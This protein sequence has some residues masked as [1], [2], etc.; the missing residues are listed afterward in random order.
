MLATQK[1]EQRAQKAITDGYTHLRT[2][3]SNHMATVYYRFFPLSD[4]KKGVNT[5]ISGRY[6][7]ET[8]TSFAKSN[9][10][11]IDI[12]YSNFKQY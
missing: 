1:D 8:L 3:V 2:V 7:G 11:A 10:D 6:S 5:N 12:S 4:I 9:P